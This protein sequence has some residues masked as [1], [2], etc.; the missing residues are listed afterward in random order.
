M[1]PPVAPTASITLMRVDPFKRA[2][3]I[4]AYDLL[5]PNLRPIENSNNLKTFFFT[6]NIVLL[7]TIYEWMSRF[8]CFEPLFYIACNARSALKVPIVSDF[9]SANL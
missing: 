3:D 2:F 7:R 1:M 6:D 9:H 8:T 5:R 4:K